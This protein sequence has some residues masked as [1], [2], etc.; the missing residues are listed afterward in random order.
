[1]STKLNVQQII[2]QN[3][4]YW[5]KQNQA[6][7]TFFN[8]YEDAYYQSRVAPS[9]NRAVYIFG[10]LISS[11]DGI[12]PLFGI[13]E[14]IYP[15]MEALFTQN[16]DGAFAEIPDV[17]DLRKRWEAVNTRLEESFA[18]M[19]PEAWLDRHT[20]V[21]EADF[22]LDPQR[23]KLNVLI[24]RAGHIGYHMGQLALLNKK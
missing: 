4:S 24:S 6:I 17:A 13:G 19:E 2:G 16:P 3:I 7:T 14:R 1:M 15:E 11:S 8:Q 12:L 22:A 21:S 5:K 10:H 18:G 23:N 20:R 9:R